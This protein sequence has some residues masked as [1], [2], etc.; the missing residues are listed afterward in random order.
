MIEW[1]QPF[2]FYLLLWYS[3]GRKIIVCE[4]AANHFME[5]L[6]TVGGE[7]EKMRAEQLFARLTIV[8]GV[9]YFKVQY[10]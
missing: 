5:I 2:A 8:P 1:M 3:T 9:D 7:E 10:C 4:E 6:N